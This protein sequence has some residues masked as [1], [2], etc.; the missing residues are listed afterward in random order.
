MS[1]ILCDLIDVLSEEGPLRLTELAESSGHNYKSVYR[2]VR[3]YLPHRRE[4]GQII[5]SPMSRPVEV[6]RPKTGLKD[7]AAA[8]RIVATYD[9]WPA[10]LTK[11]TE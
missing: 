4:K 8:G 2:L 5:V 11:G 1:E 10:L 6:E 9:V 3:L 7:A